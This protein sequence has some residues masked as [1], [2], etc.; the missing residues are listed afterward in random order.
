M[1]VKIIKTEPDRK[2][3]KEVVCN[4]CGVTLQ[5]VPNDVKNY[6]HND[7]GGGSD[8]IY[9]IDCPACNKKVDI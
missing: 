2:V 3:I 5:Y 7:Y 4:N 9:Y 1:T 6:V 8:T